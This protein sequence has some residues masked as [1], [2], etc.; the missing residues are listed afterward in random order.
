MLAVAGLI[1]VS[2]RISGGRRIAL[3]AGAGLDTLAFAA[4]SE[5]ETRPRCTV[6]GETALMNLG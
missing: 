4:L 6:H 2:S 5:S 3:L 1:E